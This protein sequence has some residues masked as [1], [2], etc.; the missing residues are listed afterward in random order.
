MA[1]PRSHPT[2][3]AA[4]I[5]AAIV[6]GAACIGPMIGIAFGIGGLGWLA[7]YAHLQVPASLL[8]VLLLAVGFHLLY[9]RRDCACTA[10]RR[11]ARALLW[12]ATVSAVAINAYEYLILPR[13]G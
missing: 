10:A 5:V 13:L 7:Q 9:R 6:T 11:N 12:L 4:G 8:T 3:A 1:L 2:A